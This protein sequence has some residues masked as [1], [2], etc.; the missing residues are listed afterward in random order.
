ME[1]Q[2]PYKCH[3]CRQDRD[4]FQDIVNHSIENHKTE[5][6]KIRKLVLHESS[7][8]FLY[9]SKNYKYIPEDL[10]KQGKEII[11]HDKNE[12]IV[13]REKNSELCSPFA[14]KMH[15]ATRSA[16][17]EKS[18]EPHTTVFTETVMEQQIQEM[19]SMIPQV[20]SNLQTIG[21]LDTWMKFHKML[22]NGTFPMDNI[23]FQ[24]FLDVAEWFSLDNTLGMRYSDQVTRFWRMGYKLFH[25]KFLRFIGGFK[26]MGETGNSYNPLDS[27]INFAVPDVKQLSTAKIGS[28]AIKPGII[29]EVLTDL[30]NSASLFC[31]SF[32]G[33]KL[34]IGRTKTGGD[35]DLFGFE[36]EPTL[37]Q[38]RDRLQHDL[39]E[40]TKFQTLLDN[41]DDCDFDDIST[42]RKDEI[43]SS[44]QKL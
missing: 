44:A 28:G 43:I 2:S 23:A 19:S 36:D 39:E 34:N 29:K 5:V 6:V 21:K 8:K 11:P 42:Q 26:N 32:D 30:E 4:S 14:K 27:K 25:G 13:I 20:L 3:Y 31:L 22:A 9:Q 12:S 15:L 33:K 16:S 41:L 35:I 24:L 38:R 18:V 37:S 17:N 7:G 10:Y 40:I 1:Q